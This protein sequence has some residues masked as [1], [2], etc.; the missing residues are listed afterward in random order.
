MKRL[1]ILI[2]ASFIVDPQFT[3]EDFRSLVAYIRRLKLQYV[4]YSIL[5]P[6][7]GTELFAEREKDL[8]VHKPELYDFLHTVLPT[9]LPL[10]EFYA[11]YARLFLN[12]VPFRRS[13]RVLRRHSLRGLI[14]RL[15]LMPGALRK[16]RLGYLDHR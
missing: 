16:I 15:M 8:L 12:A 13:V 2:S 10:R 3:H 7:P 11:E 5:T 6:L 4:W 9:T 1:G 14:S